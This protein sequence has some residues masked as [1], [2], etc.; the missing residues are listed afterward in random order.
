[1][2][3]EF[4]RITL[5]RHPLPQPLHDSIEQAL[6]DHGQPLR[7]AITALTPTE[8]TVEAVV[9]KTSPSP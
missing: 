2:Q 8:L 1:M 5:P 3:T 4:I 6:Q 9:L 7:W